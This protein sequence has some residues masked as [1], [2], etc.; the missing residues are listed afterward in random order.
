ME[1]LSARVVSLWV[2]FLCQVGDAI[3]RDLPYTVS[4]VV[5]LLQTGEEVFPCHPPCL[6]RPPTSPD[7]YISLSIFQLSPLLP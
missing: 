6:P 1:R 2:C 4:F 5:D 7:I 3:A